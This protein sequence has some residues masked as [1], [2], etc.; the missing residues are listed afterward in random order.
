MGVTK[1]KLQQLKG[2]GDI[3]ARRFAE[4]GLDTYAKIVAAGEQGLR[5]IRGI[6]PRA[7]PAILE[8]AESLVGQTRTDK[9]AQ[10]AG[11]KQ[12]LVLLRDTVHSCAASAKERFAEALKGQP[13]KKLTR[14]LVQTLDTL[15]RVEEKLH[16]RVKKAGKGLAKASRRIEEAAAADLKG[17]RKGLKKTRKALKKVLA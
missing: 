4:S 16:K 3:L 15:D 9:A 6:N 13:G 12:N 2:V 7:I 5:S 1:R 10:V 14:T 8:Q 17:V 11:L